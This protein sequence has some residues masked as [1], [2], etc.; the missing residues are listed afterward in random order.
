VHG[1]WIAL[2]S[3]LTLVSVLGPTP[4]R[5]QAYPAPAAGRAPAGLDTAL[6]AAAYR[7]AAELP[8]L[9]SLLVSWRGELVGERYFR[10]TRRADAANI[11]SAS[12]SIMSALVGIAIERGHLRGTNQ[13]LAELLPAY[14]DA[15]SDPRKRAITVSDLLSM[16]AGL[17][18][19]SFENYGSWVTSR[20][21]VRDAIRRPMVAEPGGEMI[22]STGSTHLLSAALTRATGASTLA[23]ARTR[24]ATPLGITIRRWARDPQ[25]IYFGGNDMYLTPR[26]MLR[27]GE[28]YLHGGARDGRQ[29]VPRAWIDSSFVARGRSGW[30]GHEYGYGWWI[31]SSGAHRVYFAWG[32]GGQFIFLVPSL[33]L[34]V[35]TTSDSEVSRE[36]GHLD[37]IHGL[38]D[39]YIVPAVGRGG[40]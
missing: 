30:S 20:N 13:T 3:A 29:I 8:R 39:Q 33:E 11:K 12:K 15:R 2:L 37:A 40:P 36:G 5:K 32:Y 1:R 21:W 27:F 16:R 19:T 17:Q 4:V 31:R 9:R 6:L 14:F 7:R 18:S 35:V 23:F 25:G 28:L 24:L 38:F 34:V 26:D 22:Y 10:G